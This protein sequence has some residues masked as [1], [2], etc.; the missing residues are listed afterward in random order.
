M[1]SWLYLVIAGLFEI[2]WAIGLKHYQGFQLNLLLVVIIVGMVLS[3]LFLNLALKTLPL[4][5]SYAIWTGI[6]ILGVTLYDMLW[7]N[8]LLSPLQIVFLTAIVVGILGL[9]LTS[10]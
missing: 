9:K 2:V 3:I 5:L 10:G 8:C 4:S 1:L 7:A 6:G